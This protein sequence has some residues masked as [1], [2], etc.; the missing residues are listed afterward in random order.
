M[1]TWEELHAWLAARAAELRVTGV[2]RMVTAT[3]DCPVTGALSTT[4]N[5]L[6]VAVA[7][8]MRTVDNALAR[9]AQERE[10][11]TS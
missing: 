9:K 10:G 8:T 2:G 4:A 3:I 1:I 5:D 11:R 7:T 6:E